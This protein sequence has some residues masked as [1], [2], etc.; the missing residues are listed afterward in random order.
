MLKTSMFA[1]V[2][3]VGLITPAISAPEFSGSYIFSQRT[4]CPDR[5]DTYVGN[6]IFDPQTKM[7][8][9]NLCTYTRTY[10]FACTVLDS[11][12][13]N[14]A[15]YLVMFKQTSNV[16]YAKVGKFATAASFTGADEPN[17]CVWSG[18]L[19]SGKK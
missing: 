1:F 2:G 19:I 5:D 7:A 8:H 13:S 9:S 14:N 11:P 18:T 15:H 12:Y 16:F 17:Q 6:I 3:L 4:K 10:S